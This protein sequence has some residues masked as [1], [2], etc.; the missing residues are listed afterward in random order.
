MLDLPDGHAEG[1]PGLVPC[2]PRPAL[3]A[4]RLEIVEQES[5]RRSACA[6]HRARLAP[7][8]PGGGHLTRSGATE[9]TEGRSRSASGRVQ[10]LGHGGGDIRHPL[11]ATDVRPASATGISA[12]HS[13][14][15]GDIR[16]PPFRVPFAVKARPSAVLRCAVPAGHRTSDL[17]S[18]PV[19][20]PDCLI[21][22]REPNLGHTK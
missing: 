5:T 9:S 16:H 22:G 3:V 4:A 14:W 10:Q 15:P 11:F 6:L 8:F 17:T 13:S 12:T 1:C 7:P 18:W 19:H 21:A 20:H 2:E